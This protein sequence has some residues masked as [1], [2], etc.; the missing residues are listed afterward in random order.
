MNKREA[1]IEALMAD[2]DSPLGWLSDAQ[3]AVTGV[4]EI[5]GTVDF[6]GA[7]SI[8]VGHAVSI[9]LHAIGEDG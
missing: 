4:D 9:V 2:A 1:A 6:A 5:Y 3:G 8:D 7:G